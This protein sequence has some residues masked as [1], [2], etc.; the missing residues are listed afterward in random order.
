MTRI[1]IIPVEELSDKWLLAEYHELPRCIKQDINT[2]DAPEKY[3][4]GKGHMKWGKRHTI[5]LI[6]RFYEI[7]NEMWH[8]HFHSNYTPEDLEFYAF[9]NAKTE[10]LQDYIFDFYDTKL[11]RQR[12]IEH[13][14]A[15]PK[16]HKWTK[17][18]KPEWLN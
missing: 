5:Y 14:R 15:N 11:N 9:K 17:R 4:L 12:L 3:C 13:Y 16:I 2:D 10:D 7:V 8:R 6:N 1:N 18:T